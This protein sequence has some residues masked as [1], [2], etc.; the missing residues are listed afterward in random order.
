[1]TDFQ[2][3][4]SEVKRPRLLVRAAK[5]GMCQYNRSRDLK[6]LMREAVVPAPERAMARL[7][8][9]E[10]LLEESRRAGG[11][12]YSLARHIDLLIAMMAEARLLPRAPKAEGA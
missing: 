12:T 7:I 4:L 2:R 11:A 3:F 5:L 10:A 6:R 8:D 9:E 1:M